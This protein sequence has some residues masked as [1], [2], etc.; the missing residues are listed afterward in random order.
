MSPL[1]SL[2][3][4]CLAPAVTVVAKLRVL[5]FAGSANLQESFRKAHAHH[6]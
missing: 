5:K 1:R 2:A 3:W 6:R 4:Y